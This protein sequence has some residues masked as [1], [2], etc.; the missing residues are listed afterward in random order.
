L[1]GL[2]ANDNLLVGG[3]PG[4]AKTRAVKSRAKYLDGGLS[5]IQFTRD[6]LPADI[7]TGGFPSSIPCR[8]SIGNAE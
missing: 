5:R 7:S 3:L 6:L 1:I 8:D 4:L 2:L